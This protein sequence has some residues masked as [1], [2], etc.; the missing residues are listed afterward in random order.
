MAAWPSLVL[1]EEALISVY[2]T[3]DEFKAL[4]NHLEE[5]AV[6]RRFANLRMLE[7]VPAAFSNSPSG[8]ELV[9]NAI[10]HGLGIASHCVTMV[11]SARFG[12][13]YASRKWPKNFEAGKGKSDY[14]F[15]VCDP[16]LFER[17]NQD[18]L[19]YIKRA[20]L[21][22][23]GTN[24]PKEADEWRKIIESRKWEI[25][26]GF[27]DQTAMN[28]IPKNNPA[29]ALLVETAAQITKDYAKQLRGS[30]VKIRVYRDWDTVMKQ[31]MLNLR[32]NLKDIKEL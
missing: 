18:V 2:P 10:A 1:W 29:F 5:D 17:C 25:G 26:R 21:I 30:A 8:Y 24:D 19:G 27:I 13:S 4:S 22:V 11:G 16:I 28:P 3:Q 15:L 6:L 32:A 14:D 20:Q 12:Y 23:D 7:G 9:R 31:T